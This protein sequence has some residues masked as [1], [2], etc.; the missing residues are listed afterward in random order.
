MNAGEVKLSPLQ[1]TY[2]VEWAAKNALAEE[3]AKVTTTFVHVVIEALC[4]Q[5]ALHICI[6]ACGS[7]N[8]EVVARA[9]TECSVEPRVALS[10][11][12]M[13]PRSMSCFCIFD[14][15]LF[16]TSGIHCVEA[17]PSA[18]DHISA[19]V[20]SVRILESG[21]ACVIVKATYRE[22]PYPIT[23]TVVYYFITC[24]MT[25]V[26]QRERL[27]HY[28]VKNLL[29]R[30]KEQKPCAVFC[31]VGEM[32]SSA[33]LAAHLLISAIPQSSSELCSR[34]FCIV[35]GS[36]RR[37]LV[38]DYLVF[39]SSPSF[40]GNFLHYTSRLA[41]SDSPPSA[42]ESNFR[43][44]GSPGSGHK[45]VD[46]SDT[47]GRGGSLAVEGN[48][49]RHFNI[50]L[51]VQCG[52]LF[53]VTSGTVGLQVR[54][55]GIE[56]SCEEECNESFHVPSHLSILSEVI[57]R[58]ASKGHERLLQPAVRSLDHTLEDGVIVRL[59]IVGENLH[60]GPSVTC[61]LP[62]EEVTAKVCITDTTPTQLTATFSLVDLVATKLVKRRRRPLRCVRLDFCL[63]TDYGRASYGGLRV[64]IPEDIA[65]LLFQAS[66][67][68]LPQGWIYAP[69]NELI[70]GALFVEPLLTSLTAEGS[71]SS[72]FTSFQSTSMLS[73]LA[74]VA[75]LLG[76]P[77]AKKDVTGIY[78]YIFGGDAQVTRP[79]NTEP[80]PNGDATRLKA[81]LSR[82]AESVTRD[83]AVLQTLL[84]PWKER[85]LRRLPW[86]RGRLYKEK[87]HSLL[88][89][90]EN[91]HV[92][93]DVSIVSLELS[94]FTKVLWNL[95]CYPSATSLNHRKSLHL[96]M[97][98]DTFYQRMF[99]LILTFLPGTQEAVLE[100]FHVI[101]AL[102]IVCLLLH[103][104]YTYMF[105]HVV[106]V[107]ACGGSGGATLCRAIIRESA[108]NKCSATES[109]S[110]QILIVRRARANTLGDVKEA[111]LR[112][113]GITAIVC[114]ELSD[115]AD[116]EFW[117]MWS[118]LR[119]ALCGGMG[120]RLFTFVS[121]VDELTSRCWL[122]KPIDTAHG[123][124]KESGKDG[125]AA[126]R[127][128]WQRT[129]SI[130]HAEWEKVLE[131]RG[132][133]AAIAGFVAVSLAP[134]MTC[135]RNSP[136][137]Q[138]SGLTAEE[139]SQKLLSA[140]LCQIRRILAGAGGGGRH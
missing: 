120:Q 24:S 55:A 111:L 16:S 106:V 35:F 131:K 135:L 29:E 44:K 137:V 83:V 20:E 63:F 11:P 95:R 43:T 94:L 38:E 27:R 138:S 5:D 100:S 132:E 102:W 82:H 123:D 41:P 14:A 13:Q 15:L 125:T 76:T 114:G 42:A 89:L 31:G 52:P 61:N 101:G 66:L 67:R 75:E 112:G 47:A 104:R 107:A 105:T 73:S 36:P 53:D 34:V 10:L 71:T 88:R 91:S 85:L 68:D 9:S 81:A 74:G 32:G 108:T 58:S 119:R 30:D 99:P 40:A 70:D 4:P 25:L 130:T 8:G 79:I 128:F 64:A 110:P 17:I 98:F 26:K 7:F 121:K 22:P 56:A 18:S 1:W 72:D 136:F 127:C 59:C 39:A 33:A 113:V 60:F 77:A 117:V 90:F 140:S 86:L 116:E 93:T 45:G 97:G 57:F 103:L 118:C 62:Q 49:S 19:R 46:S 50:P 23:S 92:P 129:I 87:L 96:T 2:V 122:I 65:L 109:E 48:Q 21:F 126:L 28:D 115:I 84:Q 3:V 6:V 37:M 12:W 78:N 69:P 80:I 124:G 54:C 134:S 139:F 133:G 51:G